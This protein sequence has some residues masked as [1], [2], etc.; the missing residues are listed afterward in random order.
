MQTQPRLAAALALMS[1]VFIVSGDWL[2]ARLFKDYSVLTIVSIRA[3]IG[4]GIL[5]MVVLFVDRTFTTR[6]LQSLIFYVWSIIWAI[7]LLLYG[8]AFSNTNLPEVYI[9]SSLM[10]LVVLGIEGLIFR[11]P[12][13]TQIIVPSLCL[14]VVVTIPGA[15]RIIFGNYQAAFSIGTFFAL[16]AAVSHAFWTVLTRVVENDTPFASPRG[17]TFYLYLISAVILAILANTNAV[18]TIEI[19]VRHSVPE[20]RVV[21]FAGADVWAMVIGAAGISTLGVLIFIMALGLDLAA[22]VAPYRYTNVFWGVIF[23]YFAATPEDTPGITYVTTSCGV[24]L[25]L[26]SFWVLSRR[27]A[28][29]GGETA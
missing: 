22:N 7:T 12:I 10:P 27:T 24:L 20:F 29:L 11:R 2:T 16:L 1:T 25:V 14:A 28:R 26:G 17:R 18:Q 5:S 8:L 13:S 23:T 9:I 21:G 4:T 6:V 15:Y 3:L 19:V